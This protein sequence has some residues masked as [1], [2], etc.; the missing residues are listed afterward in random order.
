MVETNV[1]KVKNTSPPGDEEYLNFCMKCGA[2][3][4]WR[5]EIH[6]DE[7]GS[8]WRVCY[9]D[10]TECDNKRIVLSYPTRG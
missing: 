10:C 4:E 5:D 1:L 7:E 3:A 2:N 8:K 9:W 6:E